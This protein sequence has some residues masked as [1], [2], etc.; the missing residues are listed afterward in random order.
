ML[1]ELM[2]KWFNLEPLPCQ[3]CETLKL[4]LSIAN[5]EKRS[6]LNLIM[7]SASSKSSPPQPNPIDYEKLAPKAMTWNVRRQLLEQEDRAQ[8]K[9]LAEQ[10]KHTENSIAELEKELGIEEVTK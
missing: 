7:S 10:R 3:S 6:L 5:D 8:A 9:I 1:K 4:A 2:Y